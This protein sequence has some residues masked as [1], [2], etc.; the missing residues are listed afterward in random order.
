MTILTKDSWKIQLKFLSGE[1]IGYLTTNS[2]N[3]YHN[4]YR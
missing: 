2:D 4:G 3:S 1:N